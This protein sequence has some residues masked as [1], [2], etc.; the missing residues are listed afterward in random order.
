MTRLKLR[1]FPCLKNCDI[2]HFANYEAFLEARSKSRI[3]TRS[4]RS[5]VTNTQVLC[6]AQH[7]GHCGH[8]V[9]EH[10]KFSTMDLN[11]GYTSNFRT[12]LLW[13]TMMINGFFNGSSRAK[14]GVALLRTA[15][16]HARAGP[17]QWH[18][19]MHL[20]RQG[21]GYDN[22]WGAIGTVTSKRIRMVTLPPITEHQGKITET[23]L[24]S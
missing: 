2:F 7:S 23:Q 21:A 11:I 13:M 18:R 10:L 1:Y 3:T 6:T 4:T 8:M 17:L 22:L 12:F 14:S 5:A 16:K 20:P 19:P 9:I 15:A 24:N